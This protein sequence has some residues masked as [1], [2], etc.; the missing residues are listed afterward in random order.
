[1]FFGKNRSDFDLS[2]S[3]DLDTIFLQCENGFKNIL[4]KLLSFQVFASASS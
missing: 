2:D 1:M 3:A 4:M